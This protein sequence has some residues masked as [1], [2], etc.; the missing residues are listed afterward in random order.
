MARK[1]ML[2][3]L[4]VLAVTLVAGTAMAATSIS[5]TYPADGTKYNLPATVAPEGLAGTDRTGGLDLALVLDSSGSMGTYVWTGTGYT[6][7][8]ALQQQAAIALV[9]SLPVGTTQVSVIEFD[10]DANTVKTLT[11]LT[12]DKTAIISAINSVNA[13]GGTA[14]DKGITAAKN[15][16]TSV[17]ARA[18]AQQM[19]VVLSDGESYQYSADLASDV[20]GNAGIKIHS[21]GISSDHDKNVMKAIVNGNDDTYG[22]SDDWGIYTD[23]S[24]MTALVDL[25][26]GTG[27]LVGIH[28]ITVTLPDGSVLNSEDGDFAVS[29]LGTFTLPDWAMQLGPNEFLATVY[30][31]DGTFAS[32][33]LTLYGSTV[34]EP[35]TILLLGAGLI[36]LAGVGRKNI[37]K[38]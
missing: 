4:L 7:R 20:A 37:F 31:N 14:I 27:S 26:S 25:F 36:G 29:A 23:A 8:R 30:A 10:S 34:P 35:G 18:N 22:N 38:K 2:S 5:W 21:V 6:T 13:D 16:L 19:M 33:T 12:A 28:H 1:S 3:L 11:L 24:D 32:A 15:E 9:N 17:R